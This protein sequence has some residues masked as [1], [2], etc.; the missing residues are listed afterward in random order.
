MAFSQSSGREPGKRG[1]V[2]EKKPDD[3]FKEL[4]L[5]PEQQQKIADQRNQEKEQ[6]KEL[7]EKM[8]ATRN[9]LKQELD[10]PVPDKAKVYALIAEMKELMGKSLEQKVEQ[11]FSLKEILTPEQLKLLN[12]KKEGFKLKKGDRREKNSRN[13][14]YHG[15]FGDR[16]KYAHFC[17]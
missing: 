9:R 15:K 6:A 13:G 1:I 10:Q 12:Q 7:K 17:Q 3:V 16:D 14:A 2:R 11:I 4:K 8:A 5:S